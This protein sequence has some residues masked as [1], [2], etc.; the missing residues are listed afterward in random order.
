MPQC[1]AKSKSTGQR[2]KQD[3]VEGSAVCHYHG[4]RTPKGIASP[5]FKNGKRSKYIDHLPPR[6]A[7]LY[8]SVDLTGITEHQAEIELLTTRLIDVME[9]LSHSP[10][11]RWFEAQAEYN[12]FRAANAA[13]NT[14]RA[15]E[16]LNHLGAI[17]D[18]G[19]TEQGAWEE[20]YRVAEQLRRHKESENRRI[21]AAENTLRLDQATSLVQFML[22]SV[23]SAVM[24]A[25]IPLDEKNAIRQ[26]I[27]ADFIQLRSGPDHPELGSGDE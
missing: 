13:G 24:S 19:A 22:Q 21:E 3:A 26:R 16:A 20:A 8:E 12:R 5:H 4:G 11:R 2:C 18:E 1:T 25:N 6:L 15:V 10:A 9:R 27:Q 23:V 7:K 17:L 14:N